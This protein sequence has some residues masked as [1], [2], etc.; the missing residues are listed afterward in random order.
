MVNKFIAGRHDEI[1]EPT[2]TNQPNPVDIDTRLTGF[3]LL[4]PTTCILRATPI[5]AIVK[6]EIDWQGTGRAKFKSQACFLQ[7]FETFSRVPCLHNSLETRLEK[8]RENMGIIPTLPSS[9]SWPL[10]V[11]KRGHRWLH[12]NVGMGK[13]FHVFPIFSDCVPINGK[14]WKTTVFFSN[15]PTIIYFHSLNHI[16]E[17]QPH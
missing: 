17:V 5:L 8:N 11:C 14:P 9:K 15:Y 1:I 6:F 12:G 7:E 13:N 3:G 4:E 2:D 10:R 16:I